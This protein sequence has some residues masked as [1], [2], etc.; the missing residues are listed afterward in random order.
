[1]LQ[2][3]GRTLDDI[4][5]YVDAHPEMQRPAWKIQHYKGVVGTAANFVKQV[6][7]LMDADEKGGRLRK[8][9]KVAAMF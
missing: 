1:V 9:Q 7:T 4:R 6:A 3:T 5:A 8:L 2:E